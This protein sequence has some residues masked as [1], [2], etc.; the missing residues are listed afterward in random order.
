MASGSRIYEYRPVGW[1][2]FDPRTSLQPGDRVIKTQPAGCPRNGTMG[3]CFVADAETG[4]FIGLVLVNSLR[5]ARRI[6]SAPVAGLRCS[7]E[8]AEAVLLAYDYRR[9]GGYKNQ[10]I[11]ARDQVKMTTGLG[12][13]DLRAWLKANPA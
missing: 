3:H 6:P 12:V 13:R 9:K 5:P 7:R 1:D 8:R 4:Q 10:V 2:A 11:A